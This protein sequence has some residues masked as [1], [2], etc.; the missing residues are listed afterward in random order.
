MNTIRNELSAQV[1]QSRVSA[2]VAVQPGFWA[3][4]STSAPMTDQALTLVASFDSVG[5]VQAVRWVHNVA[6]EISCSLEPTDRA[7]ALRWLDGS[8]CHSAIDGLLHGV[9][10][11]FTVSCGRTQV[12]WTVRPVWFLPLAD[13]VGRTLPP[14]AGRFSCPPSASNGGGI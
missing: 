7:R 1:A 11:E 13:R 9:P 2:L 12:K 3:E 14:C 6:R 8:G 4:C 10:F 5:A